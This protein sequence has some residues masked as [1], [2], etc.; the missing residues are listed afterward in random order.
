MARNLDPKCKR[1]RR[2]G[3]KLFLKGE[4]CFSPK[5]AM[6]KRNYPPGMHGPKQQKSRKSQYGIQLREKQKVKMIYAVLEK[7][8]RNYVHKAMRN[9]G[10]SGENL[11]T[12]LE[13]RLDNIVYR[14]GF[15]QSR[16]VARQL[17]SHNHVLVNGKKVNIPSYIV[18]VGD[19]ISI[20][21]T[22]KKMFEKLD[23]STQ[24]NDTPAWLDSNLKE[25]QGKVLGM[26]VYDQVK[27]NLNIPLIIEF[28]SR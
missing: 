24:K 13:T 1:C 11:M 21:T 27:Q 22:S 3:E 2:E 23:K 17:V 4:K 10:D 19:T 14:M 18:S 26:P 6:V 9:T 5:C 7:Q 25:L 28:Y 15:A 16:G 8:F 20:K 12:I